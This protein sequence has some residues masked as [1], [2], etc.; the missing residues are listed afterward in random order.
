MAK[1]PFGPADDACIL[2]V[3]NRTGRYLTAS[4]RLSLCRGGFGIRNRRDALYQYRAETPCLSCKAVSEL[5]GKMVWEYSGADWMV[6]GHL[7]NNKIDILIPPPRRV[8]Q[9]AKF[10]LPVI[11]RVDCG[12]DKVLAFITSRDFSRQ[13]EDHRVFWG[14]SELY[15][16]IL[17]WEIHQSARFMLEVRIGDKGSWVFGFFI[18][19][20]EEAS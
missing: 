15:L 10:S 9:L 20:L 14:N 11:V 2:F 19:C 4:L 16:K 7:Y 3:Q 13:L 18:H 6:T 1:R 12:K 17:P 5:L 8:S